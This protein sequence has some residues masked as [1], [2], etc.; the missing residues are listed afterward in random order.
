MVTALDLAPMAAALPVVTKQPTPVETVA[1]LPSAPAQHVPARRV[2][3][4]ER[5]VADGVSIHARYTR[6]TSAYSS[7][8]TSCELQLANDGQA[9][10]LDVN[11]VDIVRAHNNLTNFEKM[12]Q[13]CES[14]MSAFGLKGTSGIR[15][16]VGGSTSLS[17][18]IDFADTTQP[19]GLTVVLTTAD[20]G[21]RHTF[22]LTAPVGEQMHPLL[23]TEAQFKQLHARL[24]GMNETSG[25]VS[26]AVA[27]DDVKALNA[28]VYDVANVL[29]ITHTSER[30]TFAGR[31][32]STKSAVLITI[33]DVGGGH[34]K[35]T[36]NTDKMVV[37]SMLF[38]QLK[39]ALGE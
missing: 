25:R 3:L 35:L 11:F 5:V 30:A 21:K 9:E 10:V 34:A 31:T 13:K 28:R 8:A 32:N 20:G 15:L 17:A 1:Q 6:M 2:A 7:A 38:K 12:S 27:L 26:L 19:V 16:P 29:A 23:L 39:T 4:L 18:A 36:V 37:G 14:G 33:V 24:S 22:A